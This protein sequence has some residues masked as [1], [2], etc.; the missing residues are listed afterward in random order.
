MDVF[1]PHLV[2][3]VNPII[4]KGC[5][6]TVASGYFMCMVFLYHTKTGTVKK[7]T[8]HNNGGNAGRSFGVP[9]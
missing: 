6:T 8:E 2:P 7:C 4:P 3:R 9:K 5:Q 1:I